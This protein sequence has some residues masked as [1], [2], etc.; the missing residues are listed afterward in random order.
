MV[1]DHK[2]I[3]VVLDL[4]SR[5]HLTHF[6]FI[7]AAFFSND[8]L[9]LKMVETFS[10]RLESSAELIMTQKRLYTYLPNMLPNC[11]YVNW[12]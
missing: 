8:G 2:I 7:S 4:L 1:S 6:Y 5:A 3:A 11:N 9:L 12:C 10:H